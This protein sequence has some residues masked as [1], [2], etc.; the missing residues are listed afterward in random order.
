MHRCALHAVLL[1]AIFFIDGAPFRVLAAPLPGSSF[2]EG[3]TSA[4]AAES[5]AEKV[6]KIQQASNGGGGALRTEF[7]EEEVNSYLAYEMASRYP[8]GVSNV[9]VSFLPGGIMGTSLIDF[10]AAKAVRPTPSGFTGTLFW[11]KH[12]VAAEGSFSAIDGVGHF[13]LESVILD[14]VKLPQAIVDLMIETILKPRYPGLAL[15]RPFFLPFSLD[16][17]QVMR[18]SIQVEVNPLASR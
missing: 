13:D 7:S 3:T 18:G 9:Q 17:V 12:T 6:R 11:G 4:M 15:D 16:K 1:G 2:A 14:G 5:A 10:D 8:P